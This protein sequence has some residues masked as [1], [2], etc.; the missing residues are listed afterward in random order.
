MRATNVVNITTEDG[1]NDVVVG[2]SAVVQA[3][4]EGSKAVQQKVAADDEDED[5]RR[6]RKKQKVT[7]LILTVP[8]KRLTEPGQ[9]LAQK[10]LKVRTDRSR[11]FMF[12][13]LCCFAESYQSCNASARAI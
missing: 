13:E 8:R 9:K 4:V 11:V 1:G 2:C 12:H 6:H 3:S 7:E 5:D 10:T